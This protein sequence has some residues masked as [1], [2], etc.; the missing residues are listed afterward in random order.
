ML[1]FVFMFFNS[2]LSNQEPILDS[3]LFTY[4]LVYCLSL[5]LNIII[6]SLL[7]LLLF[8]YHYGYIKLLYYIPILHYIS[9][10]HI[11]ISLLSL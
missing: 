4:F 11:I 7:L 6:L 9:L 1:V 2:N 5:D 10:F 3:S 8:H